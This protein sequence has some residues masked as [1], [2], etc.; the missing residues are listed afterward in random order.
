MKF[1]FVRSD[2]PPTGAQMHAPLTVLAQ[3]VVPPEFP[4]YKRS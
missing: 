2:L 3:K 4:V 1:T